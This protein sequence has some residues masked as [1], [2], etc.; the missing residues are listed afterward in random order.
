MRVNVLGYDPRKLL[1]WVQVTGGAP[2]L[3]GKD[4]VAHILFIRETFPDVYRA[5]ATFLEPVDYLNLKL[6]GRTCASFD[7]IA[8]HWVTDNRNIDPGDLRRPAAGGDRP[9]PWPSCPTWCR[10]APSSAPSPPRPPPT[11]ACPRACRWPR[12]QG[13]CTR[14]CSGPGRWPT[15]M[16]TSTSGPRRGSR[17]HV[18]F[19]KTA[20]SSNVASIPAALAGKYVIVDEHETAGACLTFLRDNLGLA[21]DFETMNAMVDERRTRQ[22]PGAVHPVAQRRAVAGRR[23]HHP[24]RLPQPLAVH[25]PGPDGPGRLRGGG[26]QLA[27]AARCRREV[28]RAPVRLAGL[29]RRR[30]Q[31]RRRGPRS[32]PTCWVGRSARWPTRCWPTSV[33]PP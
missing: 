21:P 31:L 2:G 10:R 1:R 24:G 25:H 14:P 11:W 33:A 13:T 27:M 18:P 7:S 22:R 6:T 12:D 28:R 17:R 8:A 19:K 15:S 29:H 5:T 32:T 4:P 30:G 9:R 23:P 3:S 16:P 26:L 20:P